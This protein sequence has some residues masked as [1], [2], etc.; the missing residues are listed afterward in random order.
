MAES[1]FNKIAGYE[2]EKKKSFYRN[3]KNIKYWK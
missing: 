2:E 1:E 3:Y